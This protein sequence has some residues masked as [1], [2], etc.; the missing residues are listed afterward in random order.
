VELQEH[1]IALLEAYLAGEL[2]GDDLRA[3]EAR[4]QA[5]PALA[6]LLALLRDLAP[7]TAK[8]A[9]QS[10]RA[11]MQAAKAAAVAAGMVTYTPAINTPV[12]GKS[13]LRRLIRFLI[14]AGLVG[15][16]AWA[17]WKYAWH[18]R[19][20]WDLASNMPSG[21]GSTTTHTTITRDTVRRT[22]TIRYEGPGA[23]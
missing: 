21:H 23:E 12:A 15:G 9:Q 20:P 8:T 4:L 22:D 10:L 5:E 14:R 7:A 13:L 6:D 18:E 1:D 3:C 16:A 11:D 19:F 2:A 17:V